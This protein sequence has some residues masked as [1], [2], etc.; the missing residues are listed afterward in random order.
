MRDRP[1]W[2]ALMLALG[3]ACACQ[4]RADPHLNRA[5]ELLARGGAELALAEYLEALRLEPS[6]RAERGAGLAYAALGELERAEQHLTLALTVHPGDTETR[7]ALV[8]L[9]GETDRDDDAKKQ[10]ASILEDQPNHLGALL[11]VGAYAQTPAEVRQAIVELERAVERQRGRAAAIDRELQILLADLYARE[12]SGEQAA[13]Y[14]R[15]AR[16]ATLGGELQTLALGRLCVQQHRFAL[17]YDLLQAVLE[18]RP[19]ESDAWQ[20]LAQ[21]A[22]ELGHVTEARAALPNLAAR[23]QAR[24]DARLLAARIALAAEFQVEAEHELSRLLSSLVTEAPELVPRARLA[25]AQALIAQQRRADAGVELRRLIADSPQALDARVRLARLEL[26]QGE[27]QAAVQCLTPLPAAH[28]ELGSA[29]DI[30]GRA[31]LAL[32]DSAGAESSFRQ[33][34]SLAPE[35]P[36]GRYGVARALLLRGEHARARPL[37]EDNLQRFP[38]H[39]P[40]L[41]ALAE[42]IKRS[43]GP[44]AADSFTLKYWV[45][46]ADSAEVATLEG[47]LEYGRGQQQTRALAAYRRAI[48][49]APDYLPAASALA[50]FYARRKLAGQAF[51]VLDAALAQS[52]RNPKLLLL[53]AEVASDLRD[54]ARARQHLDRVLSIIPDYPPALAL[55]ARLD[56]ESG[57]DLAAAR[58]LAERA[59]GSAP[60]NAEVLDALGWVNHL[61]GD[62]AGAILHIG[63]ATRVDPGN[64]RYHYHLAL[65]SLAHGDSTQ[66]R[67]SLAQALALDPAFPD[68]AALRPRL[69]VASDA[70]SLTPAQSSRR[71]AP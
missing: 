1:R 49:L 42:L 36:E 53:A 9:Y 28:P 70:D 39:R 18:K 62:L 31:Q 58:Q 6:L 69:G 50:R 27:A 56:A 71:A 59:F 13:S 60:G 40:S 68:S 45:T 37:L 34:V 26:D 17:A 54:Q 16:L 61:S 48:T 11:L 25:L 47:D 19:S 41:L 66:A 4:R 21:A 64:P 35:R 30:L 52:P 20:L 22:L 33:V 32:G 24:P 55:L 67:A 44:T 63:S 10:L 43:A 38:A 7:L 2:V 8:E 14:L 5:D 57:G 12:G 15:G 65:A 23:A 46:H 3:L 29:F 51:S